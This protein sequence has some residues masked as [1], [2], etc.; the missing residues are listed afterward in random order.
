MSV[1]PYFLRFVSRA[2]AEAAGAQWLQRDE[3]GNVIPH[4][5]TP[6]WTYHVLGTLWRKG[7]TPQ[8]PSVAKAGFHVNVLADPERWPA[9]LDQFLV[10]P[11]TPDS[12]FGGMP[13]ERPAWGWGEKPEGWGE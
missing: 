8:D 4:V 3:Q 13:S 2:T 1:R 5:D 9:G 12:I 10:D 6:V 7:A 11:L